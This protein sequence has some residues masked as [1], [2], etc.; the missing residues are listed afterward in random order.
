[1][2]VAA[3]DVALPDLDAQSA[4]RL[5]V[6]VEYASG[7]VGYLPPGRHRLSLDPRQVIVIVEWEFL[8]VKRSCRLARRGCTGNSGHWYS[9]CSQ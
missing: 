2:T 6:A 1:M 8:G 9:M 4:Q 7:Q 3:I 5:S